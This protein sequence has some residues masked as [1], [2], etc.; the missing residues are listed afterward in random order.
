MERQGRAGK[1]QKLLPMNKT[2]ETGTQL[3]TCLNVTG[4][5]SARVEQRHG[6]V[7]VLNMDEIAVERRTSKGQL[8]IN[9]LLDDVVEYAALTAETNNDN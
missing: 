5:K 3:A 8:L 2:G 6:H 1:G 4:A 9:V 7:T